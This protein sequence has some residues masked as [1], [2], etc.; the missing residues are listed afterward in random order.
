MY[1]SSWYNSSCFLR[2]YQRCNI[3]S[4][5]FEEPLHISAVFYTVSY[6]INS[7][8]LR[9]FTNHHAFCSQI[10]SQTTT[11]KINVKLQLSRIVSRNFKIGFPLVLIIYVDFVAEMNEFP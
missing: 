2:R 6:I 10:F 3:K 5:L 8:F 9:Y 4:A 1:N 7:N 11:K